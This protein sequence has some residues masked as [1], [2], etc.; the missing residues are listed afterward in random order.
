VSKAADAEVKP[1]RLAPRNPR[2]KDYTPR[3]PDPRHP[4]TG[5]RDRDRFDRWPARRD[6]DASFRSIDEALA[7]LR[8]LDQ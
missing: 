2:I 7:Y 5:T 3:A 4:T 6:E 8:A 1:A